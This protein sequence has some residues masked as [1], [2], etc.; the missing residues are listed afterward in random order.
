LPALLGVALL[1]EAGV[2]KINS[3][4]RS[5]S[6]VFTLPRHFRQ[7]HLPGIDYTSPVGLLGWVASIAGSTRADR[8][9]L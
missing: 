8:K 3:D 9:S 4:F 1:I 6:H 2:A 5:G 7:G